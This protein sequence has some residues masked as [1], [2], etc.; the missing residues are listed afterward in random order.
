MPRDSQTSVFFVTFPRA[1]SS[2][3]SSF[4]IHPRC[5]CTF[6]TAGRANLFSIFFESFTSTAR[7]KNKRSRVDGGDEVNLAK[8]MQRG[9]RGLRGK[10]MERD[11]EETA[12]SDS[13]MGDDS[14]FF[15]LHPRASI[16]PPR[17]SLNA[18]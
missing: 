5:A 12:A 14:S 16:I 7:L 2:S 11:E 1:S 8:R 6:L 10:G 18:S 17:K 15:F 9:G 4:F 13:G 3:F